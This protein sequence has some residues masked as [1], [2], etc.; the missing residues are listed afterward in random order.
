MRQ[1]GGGADVVG[2]A[3]RG[4]FQVIAYDK[5]WP[6]PCVPLHHQD[7]AVAYFAKMELYKKPRSDYVSTLKVVPAYSFF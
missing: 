5:C 3:V 7:P 2:G 1:V 4:L 6:Q